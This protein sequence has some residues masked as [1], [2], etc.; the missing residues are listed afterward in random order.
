MKG[1][2]APPWDLA[3]TVADRLMNRLR[4][5]ATNLTRRETEVLSPVADGLS[6]Q[7]IGARLHLTEGTVDITW[8]A[9]MP[10]SE[11]TRAPPLWP[12]S[13]PS[14]T[15]GSSAAEQYVVGGVSVLH[16]FSGVRSCGAG[17]AWCPLL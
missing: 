14:T 11:P 4:A 10:T 17:W 8:P 9:S 16:D 15:S 2:S 7:A 6:D 12:L 5:P 13:P 1:G 3:P